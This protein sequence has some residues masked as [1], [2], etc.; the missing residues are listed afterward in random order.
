MMSRFF[1]MGAKNLSTVILAVYFL[2]Y[3]LFLTV[4]PAFCMDTPPEPSSGN[5]SFSLFGMEYHFSWKPAPATPEAV[6]DNVARVCREKLDAYKEVGEKPPAGFEKFCG[7]KIVE[8]DK[9]AVKAQ[10]PKK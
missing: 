8:A 3:L 4:E 6:A 5:T 9:M 1:L 7:E 10:I 2:C